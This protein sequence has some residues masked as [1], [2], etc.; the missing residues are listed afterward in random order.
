[1]QKVTVGSTI[2]RADN[3]EVAVSRLRAR[4]L[5][6]K[7]PMA[8]A[9]FYYVNYLK[10]MERGEPNWSVPWGLTKCLAGR[11]H[12][13]VVLRCGSYHAQRVWMMNLLS[14]DDV[15]ELQRARSAFGSR[16]NA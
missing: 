12:H 2:M 6:L 1:M 5:F 11:K 8:G 9:L 7:I 16:S 13:L 14:G 15:L 4:V 10:F 3:S